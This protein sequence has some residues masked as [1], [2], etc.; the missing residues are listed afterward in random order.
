MPSTEYI[1]CNEY[2]HGQAE[3]GNRRLMSKLRSHKN[4]IIPLELQCSYEDCKWK[5]THTT[6]GHICHKCNKKTCISHRHQHY[7]QLS[8][9]AQVL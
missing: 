1:S 6:S 2:G 9:N 3:C 8:V 7:D 5:W 4:D